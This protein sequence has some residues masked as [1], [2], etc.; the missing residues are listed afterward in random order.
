MCWHGRC[1]T[2]GKAISVGRRA[3]CLEGGE[4]IAGWSAAGG[5]LGIQV[6]PDLVKVLDAVRMLDGGAEG[7][8]H[9]ALQQLGP[10][11]RLEEGVPHHVVR[12]RGAVAQPLGRLALQQPPQQ[13]LRLAAHVCCAHMPPYSV[14][15]SLH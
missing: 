1:Q 5:V 9:L 10:L 4:V 14:T 11:E 13:A 7:R 12:A 15:P 8:G 2:T 6:G 3:A